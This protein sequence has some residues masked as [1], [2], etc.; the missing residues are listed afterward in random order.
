MA[1]ICGKKDTGLPT[2]IIDGLKKWWLPFVKEAAQC[3]SPVDA[4]VCS[5]EFETM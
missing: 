4:I 2:D 5:F 1:G 3:G